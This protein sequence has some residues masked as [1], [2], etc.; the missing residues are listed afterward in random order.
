MKTATQKLFAL[1]MASAFAL[2]AAGAHQAKAGVEVDNAIALDPF[3][4]VPEIQ[5]DHY[6]GYYWGHGYRHFYRDCYAYGRCGG[7]RRWREREWSR[8]E[9]QADRYDWQSCW[10]E[11]H[12]MDGRPCPEGPWSEHWDGHWDGHHWDHH[13]DG[14]HWDEY[15][16]PDGWDGH[17]RDGH[18]GW[19]DGEGDGRDGDHWEGHGDGHHGDH[20]DGHHWDHDGDR[21]DDGH[22]WDHD[23]DHGDHDG[24]D[25]GYGH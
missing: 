1:L 13:W 7:E 19:H 4:P 25:D 2:L 24:D 20:D 17:S 9:E 10:Y 23:G 3:D 8:Y 22:H 12:F 5:F 15:P 11:H 6:G 18:G 16:P 21:H 14:H